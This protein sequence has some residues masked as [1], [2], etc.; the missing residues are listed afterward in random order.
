MLIM[1]HVIGYHQE[2]G[3]TLNQDSKTV[4]IKCDGTLRRIDEI[5]NTTRIDIKYDEGQAK[6]NKW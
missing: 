5:E 4:E 3:K 2:N 1:L 6:G